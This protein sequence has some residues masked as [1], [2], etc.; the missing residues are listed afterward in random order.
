MQKTIDD[1][2]TIRWVGVSA[3]KATWA[4]GCDECD[5]GLLAPPALKGHLPTFQERC[6]QFEAGLLTFC[7]CRAG[8]AYLRYVQAKSV[9][10]RERE[11]KMSVLLSR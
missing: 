3:H 9:S 11:D 6:I 5:Y 10:E 8:Q 1:A 7:T 4:S 2:P